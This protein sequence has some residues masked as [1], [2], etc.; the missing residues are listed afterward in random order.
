MSKI[1]KLRIVNLN[2]NNNNFKINDE[3][4][5]LNNENTLFNLRNGGGKSV[6]VQMIT[7]PFVRGKYRKTSDRPFESYFT[8]S[9][10]SYILIEWK[11]EHEAGYLL[12]GMMVRKKDTSSDENS[13]EKLDIINFINEYRS[14]NE[15]DIE[16]IKIVEEDSRSKRVKSFGNTK[17]FFEDL[18]KNRDVKFNYYDMNNSKTSRDYFN[19]LLEYGIDHKEWEGIIKKINVKESG[20]SELFNEAKDTTGLIKKWFIPNIENKLDKDES[21]IKNYRTL[22][23]SYIKQYKKNRADIEKKEKI[24]RFNELSIELFEMSKMGVN[25]IF[26]KERLEN[27]IKNTLIKLNEEIE[28]REKR[29]LKLEE[30]KEKLIEK[31]EELNYEKLSIEIHKNKDDED[32]LKEELDEVKEWI[33]KANEEEEV[34][35]RE[36]SILECAKIHKRYSECSK[37]LQEIENK[38]EVLRNKSEDSKEEILNLGYTLKLITKEELDVLKKEFLEITEKENILEQEKKGIEEGLDRDRKYLRGLESS[39]G[40]YK[41][42]VNEFNFK[43]SKFN[44]VYDFNINRNIEGLLEE[45]SLLEIDEKIRDEKINLDKKKKQTREGIFT[46]EKEKK[47]RSNERETI[48]EEINKIKF[49][50]ENKK[51]RFDELNRD[52]E[53]R[54]GILKFIDFSE[55]RIFESK[56]IKKEFNKKT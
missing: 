54:K 15:F 47:D 31:I 13:K 44:K 4:F 41:A 22:I 9:T 53:E 11:L 49:T 10:P 30:E 6:L 21:R 3:L 2:Y 56:E 35:L 51:E 26:E 39:K 14:E 27:V 46:L 52:L 28:F 12:T 7:A 42:K 50:L 16:N 19:K 18:K 1:N 25:N 38:L 29:E 45:N 43:E 17:K 36:K 33:K 24:E 5:Y 32:R 20:L 48:R 40:E 23:E 34:A 37:K 55:E 8:T